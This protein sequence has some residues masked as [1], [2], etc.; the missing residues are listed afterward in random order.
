[1]FGPIE[2]NRS[3]SSVNECSSFSSLDDDFKQKS[4]I[5]IISSMKYGARPRL[6]NKLDMTESQ[7]R[8]LMVMFDPNQIK[9]TFNDIIQLFENGDLVF[10]GTDLDKFNNYKNLFSD[11]EKNLNTVIDD[12][13]EFCYLADVP[14]E[15]DDE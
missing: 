5:H 13:N 4:F 6:D 10:T 2:I 3:N 11:S 15:E 9:L 8:S 1:M 12:T 7:K 14:L